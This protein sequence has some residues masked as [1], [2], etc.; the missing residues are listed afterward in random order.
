MPALIR[1]HQAGYTPLHYACLNGSAKCAKLLRQVGASIEVKNRVRDVIVSFSFVALVAH[2]VT[3]PNRL[4]TLTSLLVFRL[5]HVDVC[6]RL[7]TSHSSVQIA[8]GM[9]SFE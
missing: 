2:R 5:V 6:C 9:R 3:E 4:Y 8:T 1:C 7:D